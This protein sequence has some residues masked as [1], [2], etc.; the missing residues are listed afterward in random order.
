MSQSFTRNSNLNV[1]QR[2]H[3]GDKLFICNECGKSFTRNSDLK[4]HQRVHTDEKNVRME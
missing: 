4:I 3:T 2:I 1:H